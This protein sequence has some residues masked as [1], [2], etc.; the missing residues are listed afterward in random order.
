MAAVK[1][2]WLSGI[3]RPSA[4]SIRD[5]HGDTGEGFGIT[6]KAADR[7]AWRFTTVGKL[8]GE[9]MGDCTN[10]LALHDQDVTNLAV[11]LICPHVALR[12][13]LN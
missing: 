13:P 3:L 2:R 7:Y 11:V 5:D 1:C 6:G 10:H 9:G 4:C 8:L 12:A